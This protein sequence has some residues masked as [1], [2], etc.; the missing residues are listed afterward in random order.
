MKKMRCLWL[1]AAIFAAAG[2]T[3]CKDEPTDE[4]PGGGT[5]NEWVFDVM[6]KRYLWNEE[7]RGLEPDYGLGYKQFLNGIL[8]G[9]AAQGDA[10]H[11]DGHW[12]N[13]RRQYFYSRID[14][15]DEGVRSFSV[16]VSEVAETGF[17]PR[18]G[19]LSEEPYV[20]GFLVELVT[21]GSPAAEAGLRRGMIVTEVDGVGFTKDMP[22]EEVTLLFNKVI[23]GQNVRC[24]VSDVHVD[25]VSRTFE[26]KP[27]PDV[28]FSAATYTEPVI[29]EKKCIEDGEHKI[30]YLLYMGFEKEYDR[31]LIEA[32]REFR[33]F[34]AT[35]LVLDLRY[36]G[37]GHVV[38]SALL[39]TMIAG[40]EYEG[41]VYAKLTYNAER[42][43]K[44]EE[45]VYRIGRKETPDGEYEPIREGLADDTALGLKRVFI[46]ATVNTASASELLVNGLRGLG[47]EVD[48]IGMT[49]N[50]KNVGM[51]GYEGAKV[52]NRSY[53]FYPITF[54]SENRLGFRDY[55]DGFAP[56][57]KLDPAPYFPGEFGT[58]NEV[59]FRQALAW[60]REG[61]KPDPATKPA[62]RANRIAGHAGDPAARIM[63]RHP[64]GSIVVPQER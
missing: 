49:T 47:I 32:F 18:Y 19:Y 2:L 34:G 54:Y 40:R 59:L 3:S 6:Q 10:N 39:G 58:E 16:C 23:Y 8:E 5:V 48:L 60:I 42:T 31:E 57:V 9:V 13:G 55:A 12:E 21:P 17:T 56:D 51:E 44:G 35:E 25:P 7:V 64:Q 36:N 38:S 43:A 20:G 53:D 45:G 1:C 29:Y 50:G 22:L 37:G 30:A 24:K 46:L 41:E 4:L 61:C 26:L 27:L 62:L 11:D 15:P 52:Q 14:G 33:A 63:A 28:T